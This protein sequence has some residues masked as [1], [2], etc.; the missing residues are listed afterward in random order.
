MIGCTVPVRIGWGTRS[1]SGATRILE[2]ICNAIAITICIAVVRCPIPI[3]IRW[4]TR[5]D[6]DTNCIFQAIRNAII[7]SIQI[8]PVRC[9]ITI[10]IERIRARSFFGSIRYSIPIRIDWGDRHAQGT[11]ARGSAI[12]DRIGDYRYGSYVEISRR[13]D[14]SSIRIDLNCTHSSDRG[15]LTYRVAHSADAERSYT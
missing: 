9:A 6:A 15:Q 4:G 10:R 5:Q 7:I 14:K 12:R 8:Q 3:R 1:S 13:K 2:R 11:G